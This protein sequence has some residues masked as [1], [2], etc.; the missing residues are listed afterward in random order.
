MFFFHLFGLVF[1]ILLIGS[2]ELR[3]AFQAGP[4]LADIWKCALLR[5]PAVTIV[6]ML[7]LILYLGSP[8]SGTSGPVDHSGL[9]QALIHCFMPLLNYNLLFDIFL[10]S[11]FR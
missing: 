11:H 4:R 1:F 5:A 10:A 6:L 2:Y 8:L 7:P 9:R 3:V